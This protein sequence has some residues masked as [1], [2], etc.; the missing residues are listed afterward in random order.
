[1]SEEEKQAIE[2]LINNFKYYEECIEESTFI[3][4]ICKEMIR[5]LKIIKEKLER[6]WFD[7]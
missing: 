6:E 1:M 3:T 4:S 5:N 2:Y 7:E